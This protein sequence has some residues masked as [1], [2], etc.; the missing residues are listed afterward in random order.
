MTKELAATDPLKQTFR[1]SKSLTVV[2]SSVT[3]FL[4]NSLEALQQAKTLLDETPLPL[5]LDKFSASVRGVFLP[6]CTSLLHEL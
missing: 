5:E 4:P 2:V 3:N 6:P 1:T